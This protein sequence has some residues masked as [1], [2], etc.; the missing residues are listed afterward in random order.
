MALL[1]RPDSV[2][3]DLAL[4]DEVENPSTRSHHQI[5]TVFFQLFLLLAPGG[6][7]HKRAVQ[8]S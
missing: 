7:T 2:K 5:D 8:D 4:V 6:L 1:T 3:R